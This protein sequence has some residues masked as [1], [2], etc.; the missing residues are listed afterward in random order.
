[1]G[2]RKVYKPAVFLVTSIE[3]SA[4]D[5]E[6]HD[7]AVW[8]IVGRFKDGAIKSK[9]DTEYRIRVVPD[10]RWDGVK[11]ISFLL[12]NFYESESVHWHSRLHTYGSGKWYISLP[13]ERSYG[14]ENRFTFEHFSVVA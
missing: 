2:I 7:R 10:N 9:Y 3:K 1:M 8:H 5:K 11:Q 6:R 13:V 12:D 14:V 4:G